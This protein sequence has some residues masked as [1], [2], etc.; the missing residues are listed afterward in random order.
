MPRLIAVRFRYHC[1][2]RNLDNNMTWEEVDPP[3]PAI[4][5]QTWATEFMTAFR[6]LVR[7]LQSESTGYDYM[8]VRDLRDPTWFWRLDMSGLTPANGVLTSDPL[9]YFVALTWTFN[10]TTLE[11][12]YGHFR[13]RGLAEELQ[14]AGVFNATFNTARNA[15]ADFLVGTFTDTFGGD[16]QLRIVERN[17]VPA[18]P[19]LPFQSWTYIARPLAGSAFV[20]VTHKVQN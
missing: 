20:G 5:A 1:Q 3:A 16:Y 19:N 2:G 9:P 12:G 13:L 15:L 10:R 18:D 4:T 14:S 11:G 7:A 6:P 8:D 17:R